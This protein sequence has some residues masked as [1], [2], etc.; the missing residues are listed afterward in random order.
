MTDTS[1]LKV[2][3]EFDDGAVAH[4]IGLIV[5]D[6]DETSEQDFQNMLPEDGELAFYTSRV[7]TINPVTIDNL[8]KHG[9]QLSN[10]ASLLPPDVKLDAIAYSCTSGTIAIGYEEVK[11]QI[12]AGR[13]NVPV[14]TPITAAIAAF[15]MLAIKSISLLTPYIDSVNEPLR[16]FIE[17]NGIEVKYLNSFYVENDAEIARIPGAAIVQGALECY[18]DNTDALFISC[19]A[20]RA[21]K[22]VD[23]LEA[24]LGAPVLTSN[25][26]M[27]WHALRTVGYD[28]PIKGYG[29]LLSSCCSDTRVSTHY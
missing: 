17:T 9:P 4:R 22:Q 15:D 5:L 21:A 28:K 1:E 16:N 18:R 26:C 14:I 10:A 2:K 25:Q 6:T 27:F 20:L 24:T 12:N 13:N 8:R 19:T 3:Y 7:K 29:L 11:Y 23:N